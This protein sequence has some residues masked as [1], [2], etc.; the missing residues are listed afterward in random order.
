MGYAGGAG[1]SLED[2]RMAS[3][4]LRTAFVSALLLLLTTFDSNA[5]DIFKS[6]DE[7]FQI[8]FPDK[9]TLEDL[10]V[11]DVPMRYWNVEKADR[12]WSA[13]YS[14]LP[15]IRQDLIS[16]ETLNPVSIARRIG[17]S[18]LEDKMIS[19]K[20]LPGREIVIQTVDNGKPSVLLTGYFEG[21]EK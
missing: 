13:G 1:S 11:T 4:K 16:L 12:F 15:T 20:G 19:S 5:F 9:P 3:V 2:T 8:E 17:G 10:S 6:D 14:E 7:T 21:K 18:L